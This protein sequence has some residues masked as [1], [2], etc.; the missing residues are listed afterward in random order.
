MHTMFFFSCFQLKDADAALQELTRIRQTRKRAP[1]QVILNLA[2]ETCLK[3]G[4]PYVYIY[5]YIHTY[6][7]IYA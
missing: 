5:V 1:S 6:M 7:H 3:A 2:I 4:R